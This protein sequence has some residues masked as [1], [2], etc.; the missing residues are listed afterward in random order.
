MALR[1]LGISCKQFGPVPTC[2]C[3]NKRCNYSFKQKVMRIKDIQEEKQKKN[4][5]FLPSC[6]MQRCTDLPDVVTFSHFD[7]NL[8]NFQN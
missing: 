4:C 6:G 2:L 1:K 8:W 5:S 7:L 3:Q